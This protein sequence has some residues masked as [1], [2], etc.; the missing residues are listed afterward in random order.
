MARSLYKRVV[1]CSVS[2]SPFANERCKGNLVL[3]EKGYPRRLWYLATWQNLLSSF[4][5]Q[6]DDFYIASI[7]TY[8]SFYYIS[9]TG[10]HI[11]PKECIRLKTIKRQYE[12]WQLVTVNEKEN[13]SISIFKVPQRII[14]YIQPVIKVEHG[15]IEI[16]FVFM[17]LR[18]LIC[19]CLNSELLLLLLL[20]SLLLLWLLQLLLLLLLLLFVVWS[21][22]MYLT[23]TLE[24]TCNIQISG[25]NM[26]CQCGYPDGMSPRGRM[27]FPRVEPERKLSS[28]GETF[29]QDTH[30]GI[31]YLFYHIEQT[32]IW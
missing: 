18:L 12:C 25:T 7:S 28:R 4:N 20:S 1:G 21:T 15:H 6:R 24:L 19:C 14:H 29:H 3:W 2:E 32:L 22:F 23:Q 16:C 5:S 11:I 17:S 31:A 27:V 30:T 26:P 8:L 10:N 9:T 13:I